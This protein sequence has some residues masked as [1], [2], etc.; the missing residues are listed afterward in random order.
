MSHYPECK[1]PDPVTAYRNYYH[2]AKPFA[3]W[4]WKRKAPD[5]WQG[6]QGVA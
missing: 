5:W 4:E 6:Y 2:Q 1:D 3:K